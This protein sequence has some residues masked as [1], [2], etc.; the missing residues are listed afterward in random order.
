MNRMKIDLEKLARWQLL[1]LAYSAI[2]ALERFNYASSGMSK[3]MQ[4]IAWK[5]PVET[6]NLLEAY[7]VI[8]RKKKK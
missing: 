8:E 7:G 5:I 3:D 1:S 4:K 2:D 6:Y